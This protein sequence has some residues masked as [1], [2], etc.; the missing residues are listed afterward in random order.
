[1]AEQQVLFEEIPS[2]SGKKIGRATLNAPRSL[3]SLSLEM[4]NTLHDKLM[5]WEEDHSIACVWL[6][7]AGD[8]AFCAGGDV[9]EMYN[10][11]QPPGERN[12]FTEKYFAAEYRLD[13]LIHVYEKPLICW[14][15]GVAMGGGMGLLQG[16]SRRVVTE[17]SKLAMPEI[18][19]G[20]YPDVGGSWFLNRTP[21]YT[22]LF[23]G[24]TGVHLN[25]ADALFMNL[26]DVYIHAER[27]EQVLE[28][29]AQLSLTG[30][31]RTD[32]I[33][34]HRLLR[35]E[36]PKERPKSEVREHLD[37]INSVC[38]HPT[39]MEIAEDL[40]RH[41]DHDKWFHRAVSNFQRGCPITA[42]LVQEQLVEGKYMSLADIF[43]MEWIIS[44]QCA[45]HPDFREGV[46]ALLVDKDNQPKWSHRHVD[47]VSGDLI[48]E[49]FTSPVDDHPLADL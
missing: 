7:G 22:G 45:M 39:L 8:R 49:F 10:S 44:C 21:G 36:S 1:M 42:C 3:N 6:E 13:Y 37:L 46:R 4:I 41:S 28:A 27:R 38:D 5:D 31:E 26:A 24:L 48:T 12:P 43:R 35:E 14:G 23:V 16:A 30:R 40:Q 9:V 2:E 29:L 32:E 47:E 15:N 19:I 33:L 18:T 17:H 25:A 11:M 20:L 34:I